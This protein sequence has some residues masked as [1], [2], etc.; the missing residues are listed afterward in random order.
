[1]CSGSLGLTVKLHFGEVQGGAFGVGGW[2]GRW[3][4]VVVGWRRLN[5]PGGLVPP[6]SPPVLCKA[7]GPRQVEVCGKESVPLEDSHSASGPTLEG[8]V[9]GP[10]DSGVRGVWGEGLVAP[11]G[12]GCR[13]VSGCSYSSAFPDPHGQRR[14]C[15]E[16]CALHTRS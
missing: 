5:Y 11:V 13:G 4:L 9:W 7:L 10:P 15:A 14:P 2:V 16:M 3:G 6:W 12:E 8:L 1:M